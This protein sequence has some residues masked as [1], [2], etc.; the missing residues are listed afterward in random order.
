MYFL[1]NATVG[2]LNGIDPS[3]LVLNGIQE[4]QVISGSKTFEEDLVVNGNLD[5][6]LVN[7]VNVSL[8]YSNGVQKDEDVEIV[9]DLVT[10][11]L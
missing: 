3:D 2:R 11:F 8:E 6:S 9:G 7:G 10:L 1:G 5:A 4:L